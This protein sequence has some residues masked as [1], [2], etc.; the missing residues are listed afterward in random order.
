MILLIL[1]VPFIVLAN[2][3]ATNPIVVRDSHTAFTLRKYA[4]NIGNGRDLALRDQKRAR[5]LIRQNN[6]FTSENGTIVRLTNNLTIGYYTASVGIGTPATYCGSSQLSSFPV[7]HTP[8][9]DNLA[10]DTGSS[11][12]WVGAGKKY[13][14]TDTSVETNN[15]VVSIVFYL[16]HA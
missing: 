4:R 5:N 6:S 9:T 16:A 13:V 7:S 11:N 15:S 14:R 2:A 10:V 8:F 12:L 1:L 3:I